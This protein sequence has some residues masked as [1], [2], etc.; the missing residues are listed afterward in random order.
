MGMVKCPACSGSGQVESG[1]CSACRG[2][3]LVRE[4][5]RGA[6]DP[7]ALR[8]ILEAVKIIPIRPGDI[9]VLKIPSDLDAATVARLRSQA[10]EA[11]KV[12]DVV[13]LSG[14][15]DIEVVRKEGEA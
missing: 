10:R 12:E 15:I 4:E 11:F 2:N 7:E 1:R 14:G 13:I 6:Q 9:I 3:G 5:D 8:S